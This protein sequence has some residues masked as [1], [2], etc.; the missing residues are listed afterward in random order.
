MKKL[1]RIIWKLILTFDGIVFCSSVG[2]IIWV[3]LLKKFPLINIDASTAKAICQFLFILFTIVIVLNVLLGC[4]IVFTDMWCKS[5][6][7]FEQGGL[8]VGTAKS[9]QIPFTRRRRDGG[10]TRPTKK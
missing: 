2:A 1:V 5:D 8:I 3:S 9:E 10:P 6:V 4:I 7:G